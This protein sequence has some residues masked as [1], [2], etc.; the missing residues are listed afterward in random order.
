MYAERNGVASRQLPV[1]RCLG[2]CR[3]RD[4]RNDIINC[5]YTRSR[6]LLVREDRIIIIIYYCIKLEWFL[7]GEFNGLRRGPLNYIDGVEK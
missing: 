2:V 3:T 7:Q 1:H 4:V 5:V 6:A